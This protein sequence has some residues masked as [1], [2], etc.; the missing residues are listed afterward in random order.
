MAGSL[1]DYWDHFAMIFNPFGIIALSIFVSC[2]DRIGIILGLFLDHVG[3]VLGSFWDH[4][5]IILGLF[6]EWF[7]DYFG[8][9]LVS[10][11]DHFDMI[12]LI[13]LG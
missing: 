6:W 10:F 7:W 8:I 9:M 5:G 1:W 3:S 2:W 4:F 12:F 11:W 13:I